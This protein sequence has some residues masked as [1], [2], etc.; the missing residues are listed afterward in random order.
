M[1]STQISESFNANL[2][3][4][5]K[6]NLNVEQFFMHFEMV[7]NDKRYKE[8]EVEYDSCYRLVNLKISCKILIQAREVYTKTIF[9]EFQDQ[10]EEAVD[11]NLTPC[12]V[13][14]KSFLYMLTD[15]HS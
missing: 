13:D 8:L 1:R 2:K 5:L 14:G 6:P 9:K 3:D 12:V 15:D 10:F 7:V 4:Y 11:L